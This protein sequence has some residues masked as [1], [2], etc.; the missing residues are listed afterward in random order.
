MHTDETSILS[1]Y[2]SPWPAPKPGV[3]TT[4]CLMG[5][6]TTWGRIRVHINRN[7]S[8]KSSSTV[9]TTNNL[10]TK[11]NYQGGAKQKDK[12]S[13]SKNDHFYRTTLNALFKNNRHAK[14]PTSRQPIS[15]LIQNG[16]KSSGWRKWNQTSALTI[17][18][19]MCKSQWVGHPPHIR[20]NLY[21]A[22]AMVTLSTD[23]RKQG[24]AY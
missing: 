14:T 9:S 24:T 17:N 22:E 11:I 3:R 12:Q 8:P 7:M 2:R 13:T 19:T 21:W 4:T 20:H 10:T 23:K 6:W 16:S 5:K 15:N 1:V 18:T